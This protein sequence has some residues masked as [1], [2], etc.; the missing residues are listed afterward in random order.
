MYSFESPLCNF[1]VN[2]RWRTLFQVEIYTFRSFSFLPL[3][4]G[5]VQKLRMD[6]LKTSGQVH[7]NVVYLV[8]ASL[9][10]QNS[11]LLKILQP[12]S[13]TKKLAPTSN[14]FL[15]YSAKHN[16]KLAVKFGD[17]LKRGGLPCWTLNGNI[18]FPTPEGHHH[19]FTRR[20]VTPSFTKDL[21]AC[22]YRL[23][24]TDK[25]NLLKC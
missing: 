21:P 6:K 22:N 1:K 19:S 18:I 10:V 4:V 13:N 7:L 17:H 14:K 9:W 25:R 5:Y 16:N 15:W 20:K 24:P 23:Q 2:N 8:I 3:L 12:I 11:M